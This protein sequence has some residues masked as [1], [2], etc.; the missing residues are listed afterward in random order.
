MI[1]IPTN[2][3]QNIYVPRSIENENDSRE[4][5]NPTSYTIY[6]TDLTTKATYNIVPYAV[7]LTD[8]YYIIGVDLGFLPEGEYEIKLTRLIVEQLYEGILRISNSEPSVVQ[9]QTNTDPKITYFPY[10][11]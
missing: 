2:P 5:K 11:E 4:G 3:P 7:T 6:L 9:Y 8:S 1:I 10:G